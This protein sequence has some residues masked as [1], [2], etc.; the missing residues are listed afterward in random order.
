L[1][2]VKEQQDCHEAARPHGAA[3]SPLR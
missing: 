3:G 1:L 2:H